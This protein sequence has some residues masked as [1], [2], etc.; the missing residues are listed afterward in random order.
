MVQGV[1]PI[2]LRYQGS[3]A[4]VLNQVF[5]GREYDLARFPQKS[6][7]DEAL[8][9]ILV[10]GKRPTII[11]AGANIG[12]SSIWFALRYPSATIVAVEPDSNNLDVARRNVTNFPSIILAPAAIGC[13]AGT[14]NAVAK[15]ETGYSTR[16]ERTDT[17]DVAVITIADAR[18]LAGQDAELL[19]VK[20]DIEGFEADLFSE[21]LD[22]LDETTA[23]LVETH[24]WML[25]GQHSSR[26]LQRAVWGRDFEVL[27]RGESL[28]FVR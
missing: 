1:G 13:R 11:D 20:V 18:A 14:A 22:W 6:R 17:G 10:S 3:D 7:I 26:A 9:R 19:I 5:A 23:L 21:N 4:S 8:R 27:V 16:T 25:P 28:F 15:G 2:W 12:V 24:D